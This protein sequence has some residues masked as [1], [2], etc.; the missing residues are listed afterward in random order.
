MRYFEISLLGLG[1]LLASIYDFKYRKIPNWITYPALLIPLIKFEN[2]FL[3]AIAFGILLLTLFGNLIGAG[4]IKLGVA[5]AFWCEILNWS[6]YW[7]YIALCL[8]GVTALIL[9]KKSLPFAPFMAL[10]V[11]AVNMAQG[12]GIL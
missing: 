12:W 10:G 4:D 11:V 3:V 9:R 1:L 2:S 5:I 6:Q 8:G 7:I